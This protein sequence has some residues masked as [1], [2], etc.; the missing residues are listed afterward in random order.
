V[1]NWPRRAAVACGIL[2]IL[3]ARSAAAER[4]RLVNGRLLTV[5]KCQ[6]EGDRVIL[7]MRG[8]GQITLA[9]T[10]VADVAPDEV[11]GARSTALK[12]LAASPTASAP[13]PSAAAL[14]V[15]VDRVAGRIGF[16]PKLA[17]AIVRVESNYRPLS[18]SPKGAMGLMQIMPALA[19]HYALGDPFDPEANLEAGM[20][21]MQALLRQFPLRRAVAAYNAGATAVIRYGDVPPYTETRSYVQRVMANLR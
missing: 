2:T 5:E 19:G 7:L 4:V 9:R 17:H 3:Y 8:G 13:A 10:E 20:R 11:P 21:H 12:A 15:L 14:K 1:S 18:V 16:D 6:F